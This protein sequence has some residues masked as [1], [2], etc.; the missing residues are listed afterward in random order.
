MRRVVLP[1]EREFGLTGTARVA[2]N[3]PDDVIDDVLGTTAPGTTFTASDH[4]QGDADS[5]ASRAFDGDPATGWTPAFGPQLGRWV[6][7]AL[8]GP[9]SIDRLDLTFVD[10]GRHSVPTQ[11][12]LEADGVT[13][14]TLTVGP[15]TD[16]SRDG[17]RK[18]VTATFDPFTA[19]RVR[20]VIDAVRSVSVTEGDESLPTELP[21]SFPEVVLPGVPVPASPVTVPS[22]CHDDLVTIDGAPV[23][24]RL[25]GARA[26]ARRGLDLEAC[27]GAVTLAAGSN[28]ISSATGLDTGVDVDRLVL[29][30]G[31]DAQAAPVE[32]LGAPLDDA[33][34][35]ARVTGEGRVS[36]DL[37]VR[38]D[39]SPF[40]L[41]LGQSHSDGW[42]ATVDGETLG[43]PTLVDGF[44]NGW[45]VRPSSAG[46][47]E[48]SLRW[49]P[50]QVVWVGIALSIV[51][52]VACL[53]V[54]VMTWRSRRERDAAAQATL[55]D[56]PVQQ[57]VVGY[58]GPV[59]STAAAVVLALSSGVVAALVSRWWIGLLV[60]VG[61]GLAAA[62]TR[63]RLLLSGARRSRSPPA[64]CSRCPSWAGSRSCCSP[65]TW[66]STGSDHEPASNCAE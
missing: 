2:A 61:T 24:V 7:A 53:V 1:G 44:A 58:R 6:D 26:D 3:A 41:V 52:I 12:H 51:S 39:G 9:V 62:T 35:T 36:Y 56:A 21:V 54:V 64:R 49:T 29:S 46:T 32:V 19:Q 20:L 17:S 22:E 18:T 33:G 59:S 40:W 45:Q 57:H 31:R 48:V 28:R 34:A 66:P 15:V 4:L 5:R 16:T 30:S 38:S 25:V 42:E 27:D 23:P 60:A 14:R 55:G 11:V 37:R 65:P 8:P 10:D 43:A 50:Q 63:G 13:V 47:L